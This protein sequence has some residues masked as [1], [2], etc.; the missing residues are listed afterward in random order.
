MKQRA[1]RGIAGAKFMVVYTVY[2]VY[3]ACC[4]QVAS[5]LTEFLDKE[6]S[7]IYGEAKNSLC[8]PGVRCGL[9]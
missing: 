4:S 9:R 1:G 2:C 6:L 3:P 7:E 5:E 8:L